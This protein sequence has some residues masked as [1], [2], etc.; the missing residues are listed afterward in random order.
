[1]P[2]ITNIFF[3]TSDHRRFSFAL[4][5][6]SISLKGK[7]PELNFSN[8]RNI[9]VIS[10]KIFNMYYFTP[11]KKANMDISGFRYV[12]FNYFNENNLLNRYLRVMYICT[13]L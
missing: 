5:I 12:P 11:V 3:V 4:S 2:S 13:Y 6:I 1:M 9:M 8:Y 7:E 10:F